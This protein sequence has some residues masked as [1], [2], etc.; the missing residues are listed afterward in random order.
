MTLLTGNIR[1]VVQP[2]KIA[3]IRGENGK[4]YFMHSSNLIGC[5][6]LQLKVGA[7]VKFEAVKSKEKGKFDHA[8][9]V[10]TGFHLE[11]E[12]VIK[13]NP[14]IPDRP[15]SD[16][17]FFA[18]RRDSIAEGVSAVV[19]GKN[20]LVIGERGIG[21]S[22]F[23][24]QIVKISHGDTILENRYKI[25]NPVRL[26]YRTIVVKLAKGDDIASISQKIV[27]EII[28]KYDLE[29]KVNIKTE[30]KLPAL[31]V[32]LS[33][34]Y[35]RGDQAKILTAFSYD[36]IYL[37][38]R[39]STKC[40]V[41]IFIDEI[42]NINA[43][44]G[45]AQF[46]KDFTE[47]MLLEQR[48]I[49]FLFAGI[50]SASTELFRTHKSF[51]R[52]FSTIE[53]KPLSS[54]ESWELLDIFLSNTER[55]FAKGV[56]DRVLKIAN[57][58]PKNLQLLGHYCFQ[59]DTDNVISQEDLDDALDHILT[60][61]RRK[62][63]ESR[64]EQIGVGLNESILRFIVQNHLTHAVTIELIHKAFSKVEVETLF[65][66]MEEMAASEVLAKTEKATYEISDLLFVEYLRRYY[67]F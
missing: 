49:I 27:H 5:D 64:H 19:N 22:S 15:I 32:G 44:D 36:V 58:Y 1:I 38:D 62:E 50:P 48:T 37:Y 41:Q 20:I 11:T 2:K 4:D 52:L 59:T 56:R 66:I 25:T 3:Y 51:N 28:S 33:G 47:Y 21:K 55:K 67:N 40:G 42:E 60:S 8:I 6:F 18:G 10:S 14:F 30:L 39:L 45:L 34:D 35:S 54:P 57:G 46:I 26:D 29:K 23:S 9:N 12:I 13:K 65:A 63:Y 61:H 16:P 31:T 17:H 43:Q 53:L 7:R 24:N